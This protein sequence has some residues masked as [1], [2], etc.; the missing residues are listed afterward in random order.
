MSDH[1]T[2]LERWLTD[3]R[4]AF[5]D[6]LNPGASPDSIAAVEAAHGLTFPEEL[7]AFYIWRDRQQ[8]GSGTFAGNQSLMSVKEI[9]DSLS[10]FNELH[11]SGDFETE[12]W[13][14]PSWIPVV[15]NGG[16]SHLVV[17]TN[18]QGR[19]LEFWK[20]DPDRPMVALSF[21]DWIGDRIKAFEQGKWIEFRG[22][23]IPAGEQSNH[24]AWDKVNLV[25]TGTPEGG[26]TALKQIKDKLKIDIGIGALLTGSRNP[27]FFLESGYRTVIRS[28][29]DR[30]E[31]EALQSCL[32]MFPQEDGL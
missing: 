25:L 27:P 9:D 26:L 23:Y 14:S 3:N 6:R 24:D 28:K 7:R 30:I 22:A 31:D 2:A 16:G 15:A 19:V 5:L 1:I 20:A 17:D 13:W 4:P 10:I 11:E 12:T 8:S 21:A 32:S 18:Q 29:L